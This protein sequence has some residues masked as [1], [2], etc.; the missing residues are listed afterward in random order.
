[1][2]FSAPSYGWVTVRRVHTGNG[3]LDGLHVGLKR[4]REVSPGVTPRRDEYSKGWAGAAAWGAWMH[5]VFLPMVDEG[6]ST[7]GNIGLV[8]TEAAAAIAVY[9]DNECVCRSH[10]GPAWRPLTGVGVGW[11]QDRVAG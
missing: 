9:C 10:A 5:K 2:R 1:M 7:N 11:A 6:A 8:M 4:S 3:L